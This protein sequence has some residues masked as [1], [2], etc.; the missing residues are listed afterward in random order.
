M[1][2]PDLVADLAV[3]RGGNKDRLVAR[4]YVAL[5]QEG[6]TQLGNYVDFNEA[7]RKQS[8]RKLHEQFDHVLPAEFRA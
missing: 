2:D 4:I 6:K 7:Y 8:F 3:R 5:Q 1:F